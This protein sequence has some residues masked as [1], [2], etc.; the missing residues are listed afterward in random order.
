ME[1][2]AT[3]LSYAIPGFVLLVIIEE[4]VSRWMGLKINRAFP[5]ALAKAVAISTRS[6]HDMVLSIS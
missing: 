3:A 1:A 2:Y 6:G 5:L 4:L